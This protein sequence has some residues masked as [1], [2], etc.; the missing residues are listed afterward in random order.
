MLMCIAAYIA[1]VSDDATRTVRIAVAE[2]GVG[3]GAAFGGIIASVLLQTRMPQSTL[4]IALALHL[5]SLVV[6][7]FA[8]RETRAKQPNSEFE[9]SATLDRK[10]AATSTAA[11]KVKTALTQ[12]LTLDNLRDAYRT[13]AKP[14][15]HRIR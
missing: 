10:Q 6:V 3:V 9:R 4:V 7:I 15:P 12:L 1:D 14:R 8:V 5:L 2:S 11:N 13:A